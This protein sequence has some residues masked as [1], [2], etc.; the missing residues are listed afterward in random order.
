[1]DP[2]TTLAGLAWAV[3]ERV[4]RM[5]PPLI[6]ARVGLALADR[7]DAEAKRIGTDDAGQALKSLLG[8]WAAGRT[9]HLEDRVCQNG[10]GGAEPM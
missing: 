2:V 5:I 8:R 1:M 4:L 10:Q 3:G 6:G 7:V 9:G